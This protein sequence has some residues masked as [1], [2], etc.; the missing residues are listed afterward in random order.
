MYKKHGGPLPSSYSALNG[1]TTILR[2]RF[3]YCPHF[4][5]VEI[6]TGMVKPHIQGYLANKQ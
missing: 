3:C 5:E 1:L 2:D 6:G 4:I